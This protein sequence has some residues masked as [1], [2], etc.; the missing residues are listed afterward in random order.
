MTYTNE[1]WLFEGPDPEVGIFG[2]LIVH[3]ACPIVSDDDEAPDNTNGGVEEADVS[4]VTDKQRRL[5]T[6]TTTYKCVRCGATTQAS[7]QFP[8]DDFEN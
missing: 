2:D 1:G 5:V 7:E 8:A 4:Y 3:D 6:M